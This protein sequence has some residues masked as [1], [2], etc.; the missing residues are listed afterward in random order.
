MGTISLVRRDSGELSY[1]ARVGRRGVDVTTKT[2]KRKTD[3][4]KWIWVVESDLLRGQGLPKPKRHTVAEAIDRYMKEIV[5]NKKRGTQA[6]LV[7]RLALWSSIL[8]ARRLAEVDLDALAKARE[9][10]LT[11]PIERVGVVA[12]K[13]RG[14]ATINR[15]FAILRHVYSVAI[16]EWGWADSNPVVK[17]RP[18]REPEGRERIL[19]DADLRR[20]V[21]TL[22]SHPRQDFQLIV[23]IALVTGC[24]RGNVE[25]IRWEH[26]DFNNRTV[27]FPDT[28][29]NRPHVAPLP[30]DICARLS[31]RR[32]EMAAFSGPVFPSREG[33]A[34]PYVDV[35]QVWRRFVKALG[36]TDLRFHD[37]RHNVGS[38]LAK[39]NVSLFMIG[40]VLGH[41]SLESTKRYMHVGVAD[42]VQHTERLQGRISK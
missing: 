27:I 18:F 10:L 38:F 2:F 30:E 35:K 40:K 5:P 26:I 37:L 23:R 42:I 17:I 15:Y 7:P 6:V 41:R 11:T 4:Q 14:P 33:S 13:L 19:S 9:Y 24:R 36:M 1:R 16:R 22:D 29:N 34:S 21:D 39:Q 31:A 28:K 12:T 8:G 20:I 25:S 3:A 32:I